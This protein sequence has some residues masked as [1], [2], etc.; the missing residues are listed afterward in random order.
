MKTPHLGHDRSCE[1]ITENGAACD[2]LEGSTA[3]RRPGDLASQV[4]NGRIDQRRFAAAGGPV[5][6]ITVA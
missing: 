2:R 3:A 5:R 4:S 6:P 1:A